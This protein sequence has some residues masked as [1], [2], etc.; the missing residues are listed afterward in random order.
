MKNSVLAILFFLSVSTSISAQSLSRVTSGIDLGFG[1]DYDKKI[2]VP[3]V[4]YHQ[5]LSLRNFSWFNIGWGVRTSGYYAGR[6]DL[7]PKNTALSGDTLKFGKVTS[8]SVSFL[9]GANVRL[10]HF[11]IGANTD[12]FGVTFGARRRG[13][14]TSSRLGGAGEEYYN[15]YVKS[16]PTAVHAL[17]LLLDKQA[18]Q[19]EIY[20]RYWITPR[21]GV[22]F[23]Y[24]HGR[25]TYVSEVKL[26][27]DQKRFSTTYGV[28]YVA[29]SFPIFN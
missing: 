18:G 9:L 4:T 8:N 1:Y 6:T 14:Y 16:T 7:I 27:N 10:W 19:S 2:S 26:N 29:L 21:I 24:I 17:P 23:A 3:A 12:I 11:E 15:A 5:E 25:T 13:L 22:K 20:L 28:P